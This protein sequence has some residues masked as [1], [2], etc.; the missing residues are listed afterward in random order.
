[1]EY[2]VDL[3]GNSC[4]SP[5]WRDQQVPC[6]HAIAAIEYRDRE[7]RR[8][9]TPGAPGAQRGWTT[10]IPNW[11]TYD[12]WR[13]TYEAT[14]PQVTL[15][16]TEDR[17]SLPKLELDPLEL[18]EQAANALELAGIQGDLGVSFGDTP[19]PTPET[20]PWTGDPTPPGASL[21]YIE[22]EIPHGECL[23][24][25]QMPTRGRPKGTILAA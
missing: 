13:A 15:G 25:P 21:T 5:Y 17:T 14:M 16:G 8:W 2:R 7:A 6:Y 11:A 22:A 20:R 1:V 4:S 18:A 23:A 10:L 24:P 12:A 3:G 19:G 9:G